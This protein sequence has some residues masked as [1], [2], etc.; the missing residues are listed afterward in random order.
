MAA[1]RN[2][3]PPRSP[4][5][6]RLLGSDTEGRRI[7]TGATLVSLAFHA[8]ALGALVVLSAGAEDVVVEPS[9]ER[10][11]YISLTMPELEGT[12]AAVEKEEPSREPSSKAPAQAPRREPKARSQPPAPAVP[13]APELAMPELPEMP[14]LAGGLQALTQPEVVVPEI[15]AP[16][17]EPVFAGAG[18]ALAGGSADGGGPNRVA[19]AGGNGGYGALAAEPAVTPYSVAP[20]LK[21]RTQIARVLEDRYPPLL[22]DRGIG[23]QTV[24]W[25][26]IDEEGN[27][28]RALVKE[29]SGHEA[30]DET[31]LEVVEM[32]RFSPAWNGGYRVPVWVAVPIRFQVR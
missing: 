18:A 4:P 32:M 1:E 5:L 29:S 16:D 10:I 3:A 24:L 17:P 8:A 26:F 9:A 21:N 22:R 12:P 28:I 25:T 31:A 19:E 13:V 14:E 27:V 20:E 11:T 2:G 15:P 23:G 6:S 7:P 30:L